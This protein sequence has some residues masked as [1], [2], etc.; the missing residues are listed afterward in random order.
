MANVNIIVTCAPLP[1]TFQNGP[2]GFYSAGL[3]W[4]AGTTSATLDDLVVT[5]MEGEITRGESILT[6]QRVPGATT[7]PGP[8]KQAIGEYSPSHYNPWR[9]H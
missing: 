1:G 2:P 9:T 8:I 7:S 5:R 3:F 6:V 4:P